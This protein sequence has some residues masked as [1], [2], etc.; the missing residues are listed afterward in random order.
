MFPCDDALHKLGNLHVIFVAPPSPRRPPVASA[1]ACPKAVVLLFLHCLLL[2]RF[3]LGFAF[4]HCLV[5]GLTHVSNVSFAL[6]EETLIVS[7]FTSLPRGAKN[8][9]VVSECGIYR[10]YL[11]AF[12]VRVCKSAI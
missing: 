11:L 8:W 4:D 12:Q 5:V 2:L 3:A 7:V 9:S 6:R 10:S 1:A